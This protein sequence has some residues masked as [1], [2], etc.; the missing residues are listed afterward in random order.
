MHSLLYPD[1]KSSS[2]DSPRHND[3]FCSLKIPFS[4]GAN[5]LR[6]VGKLSVTMRTSSCFQNSFV[7]YASLHLN[8][9]TIH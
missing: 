1:P 8:P 2:I 9:Y 6:N 3:T 4:R 5:H 7:F